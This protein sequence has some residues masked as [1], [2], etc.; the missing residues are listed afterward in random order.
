MSKNDYKNLLTTAFIHI[1]LFIFAVITL[2]LFFK[3]T[4]LKVLSLLFVF[5]VIGFMNTYTVYRLTIDTYTF[6]A[7]NIFFESNL[8]EVIPIKS[9]PRFELL[10]KFNKKAHFYAENHDNRT[11]TITI[12]IKKK[13]KEFF[14]ETLSVSEF[15]SFYKKATNKKHKKVKKTK[16]LS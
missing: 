11:V 3:L 2:M 10:K 14:F 9:N 7:H 12:R 5:I 6:I 16:N 8:I 1:I 15:I 4:M 13:E